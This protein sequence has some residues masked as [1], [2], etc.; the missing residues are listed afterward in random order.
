MV[1]D[2]LAMMG[3]HISRNDWRGGRITCGGAR[4]SPGVRGQGNRRQK[5]RS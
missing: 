5:D 4:I 2:A 3:H 1:I